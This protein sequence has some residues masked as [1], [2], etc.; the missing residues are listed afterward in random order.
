MLRV[1]WERDGQ[2]A[3]EL[4]E[5][6]QLDAATMVGVLDRLVQA[7]LIERNPLPQDRRVNQVHLTKAGK[8]LHKPLS[9]VIQQINQG[10][11]ARFAKDLPRV[12]RVLAKLG[13]VQKEAV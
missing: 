12:R 8:D 10:V 13:Q 4:G 11:E 3:A 9:K 5:R 2:S 1:L 7:G 6:L